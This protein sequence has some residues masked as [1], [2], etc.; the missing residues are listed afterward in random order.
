[1]NRINVIVT[2]HG[3]FA[4]GI[5]GALNLLVKVPDNWQFVDFSAGMS[6]E[7]LKENLDKAINTFDG[8]T[9][10][11]TDLVGGTPYKVAAT[12]AT[13]KSGLAVVSGCN[14]GSLLEAL[15]KNYS[16][17]DAFAND[18]IDI[19]KK[20]TQIFDV[21]DLKPTTSTDTYSDGI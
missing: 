8:E 9:L 7:K 18:L 17:V 4:T 19:S 6:D 14:L 10:L 2:G 15:F 20:G 13:E 3:T 11:F 16:D 21:T 1:M 12:L 5:Q